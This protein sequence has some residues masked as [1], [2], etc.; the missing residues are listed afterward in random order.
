MKKV[1]KKIRILINKIQKI[2]NKNFYKK[3][4]LFKN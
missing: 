1:A 3:K 2:E 4:L